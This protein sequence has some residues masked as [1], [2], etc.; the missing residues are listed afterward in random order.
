MSKPKLL[1][2]DIKA[3]GE[4]I[5]LC[6]AIAGIDF[7][8][9]RIG[10]DELSALKE[11]PGKLPFGQLPVVEIDGKRLAQTLACCMY[12]GKKAGLVPTDDWE[13]AKMFEFIGGVEDTQMKITMSIYEQ[14][15]DKKK[16]MRE[17]L[18]TTTLPKWFGF[19]DSLAV[20]N[21]SNGYAVGSKLS[22]AD[23]WV[24]MSLGWIKM[25]VLD[26][27]PA[28]LPDKYAALSKVYET[29]DTHPKVVE[30]NAAHAKPPQ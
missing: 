24:Y 30:W 5:R 18:A 21:G 11:E 4:P 2:F 25:G 1:Y 6:F 20:Q 10:R 26:G 9:V 16:K 27:I 8:D 22:L 29:V 17:D 19:L 12:V 28:S 3:R 7:D 14:D 13:L 23:L 15:A